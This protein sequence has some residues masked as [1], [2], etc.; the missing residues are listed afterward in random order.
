MSTML[1]NATQ[2]EELRVALVDNNK[3]LYDYIT[4]RSGFEE[5]IGNIYLGE[6]TSIEPSL[7]AVFVNYGSKRHGFLPL[8]EIAREYFLT[9]DPEKLERPNIKELLKEG[10]KVLVQVEK[11]ERGNKGA[12]LTTF[13]SLAGSYLVLMPNN[14]SAGG[15]SRRI[16]GEDRDDLR[17]ILSKLDIPAGMGLIVRTAGVGRSLE[18]LQWDLNVLLNFWEA[19]KKASQNRASPLLIHQESD[20]VIRAIRDYLRQDINEIVIDHPNVFEKA[21]HYIE[22]VRPDYITRLKLYEEKIPL[23]ISH[24]I[25]H[26]IELAY[27]RTVRLKSGGSL[28]IDHTEALVSIDI[29][30]ARATKGGDIEETALNTNLEAAE[31]IARQLR[32][33]DIGGLIVIDFIDMT[34]IRHQRDVENH[35]RNALKLDRARVQIGRISRFGLLE[36]SRQ[37]LRPSLQE[38]IQEICPRCNGQGSIRSVESLALTIIRMIEEDSI[39]ENTAQIQLQLSNEAATYLL[40]EKRGIITD[41]EQRQHVS[42]LI[43]PNPNIQYPNYQIKRLRKTDLIEQSSRLQSSYRMME[44]A[45]IEAPA[46]KKTVSGKTQDQPV[47]KNLLPTLPPA[48]SSKKPMQGLIKRLWSTMVSGVSPKEKDKEGTGTSEG[49]SGTTSTSTRRPQHPRGKGPHHKQR[50]RTSSHKTGPKPQRY[51]PIDEKKSHLPH[52]QP[53]YQPGYQKSLE[54]QQSELQSKERQEQQPSE[55]IEPQ[56]PRQRPE[57][58][59]RERAEQQSRERTEHAP[60]ERTESTHRPRREHSRPHHHTDNRR[61]ENKDDRSQKAEEPTQ[62]KPDNVVP[63]TK[64]EQEQKVHKPIEK[65]AIS[66]KDEQ[67]PIIIR[68]TIKKEDDNTN[69]KANAHP[70]PENETEK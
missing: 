13:I 34:P 47:V 41:I 33:R 25:E 58:P 64:P 60:R 28:V 68:P 62:S 52:A 66:S 56:P 29:N 45:A 70:T 59:P 42:I 14:P 37:R 67:A 17:E 38:A 31:E 9:Q 10:Q 23:F 12:A 26:Q 44:S 61:R 36:M 5:K 22:Q 54:R 15:I 16:E 3:L 53:E 40:N 4:E 21:K 6:I 19:I 63:I 35:L 65:E 7:D 30:S 8:K 55:K 18:E 32:L 20:V 69:S 49:G 11:E 50:Q 1:I 24:E 51:Q 57:Q 48:P 46:T 39:K 27:Q 2:A 43:I